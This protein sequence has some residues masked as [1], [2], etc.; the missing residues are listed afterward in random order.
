[1]ADRASA[2]RGAQT[3]TLAAAIIVCLASLLVPL[4][5]W[6]DGDFAVSFPFIVGLAAIT[7]ILG[8]RTD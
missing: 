3:S 1:M 7:G 5:N 8:V 2:M 4:A 6:S